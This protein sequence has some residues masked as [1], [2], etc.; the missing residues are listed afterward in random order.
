[1]RLS[2]RSDSEEKDDRE[3][4]A[5]SGRG[6]YGAVESC[7]LDPDMRR[8]VLSTSSTSANCKAESLQASSELLD[9]RRV[10]QSEVR[11]LFRGIEEGGGMERLAEAEWASVVPGSAC[12]LFLLAEEDRLRE[13]ETERPGLDRRGTSVGAEVFTVEWEED[14]E[15]W[16]ECGLRGEG[17]AAAVAA[18]GEA[19]VV[20]VAERALSTDRRVLKFGRSMLPDA[21]RGDGKTF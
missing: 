8:G 19:G 21:P 9:S 15:V 16:E 12:R 14:D 3:V 2:L 17:G 18:A 7:W 13:W 10:R 1:M 6:R 20:A 5:G 4:R 11:G